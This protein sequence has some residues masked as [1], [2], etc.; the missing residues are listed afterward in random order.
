MLNNEINSDSISGNFRKT[1]RLSVQIEL[2]KHFEYT[3]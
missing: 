2:S 3:Y 1:K